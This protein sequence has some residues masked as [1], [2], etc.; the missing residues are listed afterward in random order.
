[1]ISMESAYSGLDCYL[2][3]HTISSSGGGSGSGG[4][5]GGGLGALGD[6]LSIRR[7]R[8]HTANTDQSAR[9]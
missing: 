9:E 8:G 2:T 3:G 1:M 4:G 6:L 5:C 7:S